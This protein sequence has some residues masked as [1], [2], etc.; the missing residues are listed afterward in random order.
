MP[1]TLTASI[2]REKTNDLVIGLTLL[3]VAIIVPFFHYQPAVGP[4][5][6]AALFL[7]TA[8]I[9]IRAGVLIAIIP[10]PIAYLSGLLPTVLLPM[11]PFIILGNIILV[12]IFGKLWQ[13]NFWLGMTGASVAKFI[14]LWFASANLLPFLI[15]KTIAQKISLMISWPQ[16]FT[17]LTGGIIAYGVLKYLKKL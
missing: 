10:S 13:K 14:F 11:I 16:L 3:G 6:N 2:A 9:N 12:Y 17:A 1:K 7:S 15:N 8:L 5:V 4:I